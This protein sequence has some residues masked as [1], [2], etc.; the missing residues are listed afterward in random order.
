MNSNIFKNNENIIKS[1]SRAGFD[2]YLVG[3]AVR[4]SIIGI[5]NNDYDFCTNM[6]LD[7]VKELFPG[8]KIMREN[9][10][11][12]TGV[13]HENGEEYEISS[14]HGETIEEDLSNRDFTINA[15]ACDKD[16]NIID[17]FNGVD[18]INNKIIRLVK[19]N[20]E[21][22][23]KD[24]LRI[25]RA[26]RF[27]ATYGFDIDEN[28]K[29]IMEEKKELLNDVA[30]ERIYNELKK[31]L[32]SD[33]ASKVIRDNKDIFC[34]IIPELKSTI[35]FKQNNPYHVF[36]VF[37]HTMKVIDNTP[38]DLELRLAAL[39]HDIGKPLVYTED[40]EGV[41]HFYEHYRYSDHIFRDF[42]KKYRLDKKTTDNTSKLIFNHDRQ[43]SNKRF[44]IVK[45][46]QEYGY[47]D[48]HKLFLLKKADILAQN[49]K[50][51]DRLNSLQH[52]ID[53]YKKVYSEG[54]VLSNRDVDINGHVLLD[55][56]YK[57]KE[58][59]VILNDVLDMVSSE[60]LN[61]NKDNIVNY[62][63]KKYK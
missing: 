26:I 45:F 52:T 43:L 31:I 53:K 41:G 27:S 12:N 14:F 33:N 62:V 19:D 29:R 38:C 37:E 3:G 59:G 15:I 50:Y 28:T 54:P 49:P 13:L 30:P 10:H 46:L 25:L 7:K 42:S 57:G 20:G 1:I 9:N 22:I 47:D 48:L 11:R 24:P 39:F 8:F 18:D 58:I 16:G 5:D 40:G 63:S 34:T 51:Y 32:V 44:K 55:M 4:D 35:N 21:A 6:S 61:N 2:L 23:D 56:G 60:Q 17:P 36:D